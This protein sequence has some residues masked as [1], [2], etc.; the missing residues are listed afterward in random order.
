[1]MLAHVPSNLALIFLV[2]LSIV[3]GSVVVLIWS[4]IRQ[5]PSLAL[6]LCAGISLLFGGIV[7]MMQLG[8]GLSWSE[9]WPD[10]MLAIVP[11]ICGGTATVRLLY[12][13]YAQRR[14]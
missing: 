9:D 2:Y 1:M 7:G 12:V 5:R 4:L 8:D 6:L 10:R 11:L 13:W 14:A 3:V